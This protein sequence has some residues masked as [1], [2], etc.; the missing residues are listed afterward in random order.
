MVCLPFNAVGS[1]GGFKGGI[2]LLYKT[3]TM[4]AH[5]SVGGPECMSE[6]FTT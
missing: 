1:D 5:V 2:D 3:Y 4:I 6:M